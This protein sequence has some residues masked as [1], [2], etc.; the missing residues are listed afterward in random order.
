MFETFNLIPIEFDIKNGFRNVALK[1]III[2]TRIQNSIKCTLIRTPAWL[3]MLFHETIRGMLF[4]AAIFELSFMNEMFIGN[5]NQLVR[6]GIDKI[7]LRKSVCS[8]GTRRGHHMQ[9][10]HRIFDGDRHCK[11]HLALGEW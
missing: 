11:S 1:T 3:E 9:R 8:V 2:N 4:Q 10:G 6:H 7:K 5:E